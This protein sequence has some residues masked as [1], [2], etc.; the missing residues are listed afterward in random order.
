MTS[1]VVNTEAATIDFGEEI[2]PILTRHCTKCHGGVK[3]AGGV[4]FIYKDRTLGF[5]KSGEIVVSPGNLEDSA[6]YHRIT[7]DDPDDRMPPP[8]ESPEGLSAKEIETLKQWIEEGAPWGEHWAYLKPAKPELPEVT[9]KDWVR[10]PLDRFILAR[11]EA[12]GLEPAS[13]ASPEAWLRRISLDLTGLPPTLEE[14][15]RF[16]L[17]ALSQ[18][19]RAYESAVDRLLAS[20][21]FGERW[22]TPWLDQIRYADSRGLGLDDRRTIWKYRDWVVNALNADMPFDDFTIKQIAGDLLPEPTTEDLIATACHRATQASNEGGTDDEMFRVAAVLDRANTTWQTW[23]GITFGCAQCHDHPYEPITQ[24]EYYQFVSYFNNTVDSDAPGDEPVYRVPLNKADYLKARTLQNEADDLHA[25]TWEA[26]YRIAEEATWKKV[27]ILE[28]ETN[29][30]T[31]LAIDRESERDEFFTVG[32]I[33]NRPEYTLPVRLQNLTGPLTAIRLHGLPHEP[34]T[35]LKDSEWGFIISH[36]QL[37]RMGEGN[38]FEVIPLSYVIPDEAYSKFDPQ[39]SLNGDP[40]SG[41]GFGPYTRIHYPRTAVFVL[42][43]PVSLTSDDGRLVVKIRHD[44][45]MGGAH[46]LVT[47]RG[48]FDY[49]TDAKLTEF[50]KDPILQTKREKLRQLKKAISEIPATT[51]PVLADRPTRFARPTHVFDRGN[52]LNKTDSVES[53][54]PNVFGAQP[55]QEHDRFA[56]ASWLASE[57]NPLTARVAVNRL[58]EQMFGIGLVSSLEDFGVS[59][60]KPTHPDLLDYLAQ[61]FQTEYQWS[62]KKVLKEIA[63]SSTYRQSSRILPAQATADPDN[64]LYT[65]GP[66]KRLS[67]EMVRDQAL[68]VSGL[69]DGRLGGAPVHPPIPAGVWT[70]FARDAWDTK[71]NGDRFRRSVYTYMKRSIPYPS[72]ATFDAPSREFCAP[73]RL[74]SN[75]PLQALVTLNDQAFVECAESLAKRMALHSVEIR[76]Q[77]GYGYR[78]ITGRKIDKTRE[79][80]LSTLY[81]ETFDEFSHQQDSAAELRAREVVASVLLNMDETLT[82]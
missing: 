42:Q 12:A 79:Q 4:S 70:P 65:R 27:S 9:L 81:R 75:T 14:L 59:G 64:R 6:L 24:N 11:H 39:D 63:L 51:V 56:M 34:E 41:G 74:T 7:T 46:P 3:Q 26:G 52:Y 61:R 80:Q 76:S 54:L 18:G 37:G 10:Q 57:E 66:R 19:D 32:T 13:E 58:W 35:A 47:K 36:F 50:A 62:V 29:N 33:Q 15:D 69:L 31:K 78:L 5:A 53:G 30:A 45:Q 23:Q 20:R 2:Q 48:W 38:Q 16:E 21:S 72:F 67:A 71:E 8:E 77:I 60:E 17:L 82:Y 49:S 68:A 55:A 43:E 1:V 28:A 40:K 22:A 44:I 73:R 25:K